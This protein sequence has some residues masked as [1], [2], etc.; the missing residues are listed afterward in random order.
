MLFVL[1]YRYF[2]SDPETRVT[3]WIMAPILVLLAAVCVLWWSFVDIY[4]EA[5]DQ[6]RCY[7]FGRQVIFPGSTKIGSVPFLY[8]R[9]G[10]RYY[11]GGYISYRNEAGQRRFRLF[12]AS[13]ENYALIKERG[14]A[15]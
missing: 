14:L 5:D 8:A 9:T 7:Y 10:F 1:P 4:Q 12:L 15:Q 6:L 11:K 3:I 2:S 13:D